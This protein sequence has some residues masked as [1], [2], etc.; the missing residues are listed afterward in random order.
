MGSVL[1][2]CRT[3]TQLEQGVRQQPL[4]LPHLHR[5][6]GLGA[7]AQEERGRCCLS[8]APALYRIA[9]LSPTVL[10]LAAEWSA[11]LSRSNPG[12]S[13]HCCRV[14]E[15]NPTRSSFRER[16][17]VWKFFSW[18]VMGCVFFLSPPLFPP[19]RHSFLTWFSAEQTLHDC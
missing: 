16:N 4:P 5:Q 14:C 9:R 17:G 10:R 6:L 12:L 19:V 7:H 3:T 11:L 18:S 2:T 1:E 8:L 15:K 13:G